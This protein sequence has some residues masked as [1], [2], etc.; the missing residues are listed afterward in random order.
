[1]ADSPFFKV[2]LAGLD[3]IRATL[4]QLPEETQN[5]VLAYAV[6]RAAAPM[7]KV[8][9]SLAPVDT[10]ALR[11]S[12]GVLVRK[13]KRGGDPYAIIGP[14]R[15]R[16]FR[17]GKRL[18]KGADRRGADEPANYAHLVE[19]GHMSAAA[20][21][22][23]VASAKGS[24]TRA[25]KRN[26]KTQFSARSF[27]LPR[28]FMRPAVLRT[29]NEVAAALADGIAAGIDQAIDRIVKNPAARG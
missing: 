5:K 20:S 11:A 13:G 17:K 18:K 4:R 14:E 3:G 28:P 24:S 10:G 1:M 8:A 2:S 23:S 9:K 22:T 7:V 26:K 25:N 19:F 16:Y 29:Q 6:R 12:I 27:V 15:G 21:G